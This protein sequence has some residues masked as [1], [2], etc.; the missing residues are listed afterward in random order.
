MN[1]MW[2]HPQEHTPLNFLFLFASSWQRVFPQKPIYKT[3]NSA[4]NG[5][6]QAR[7]IKKTIHGNV[8]SV[9]S[10]NRYEMGFIFRFYKILF[11]CLLS[12][13]KNISKNRRTKSITIITINITIITIIIFSAISLHQFVIKLICFFCQFQNIFQ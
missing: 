10:Y 11:S 3:P 8:K 1:K 13:R 9:T 7:A 12:I 2:G 6:L 5:L 4:V